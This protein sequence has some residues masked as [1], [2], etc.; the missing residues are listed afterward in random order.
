M[1]GHFLFNRMVKICYNKNT[2][3]LMKRIILIILSLVI[4]FLGYYMVIFEPN[5]I[6]IE[7]QI[8]AIENLPQSFE[9]VRIVHLTD[10]HS[11]WFGWREKK[12]LQILEELEPDFVFL[13]GDFVDPMTK[14]ITDRELNSVKVFWQELGEKYE[15][16][17]FAV[18]GNHDP[19]SLKNL[20]EKSG[21][22]VLDNENKKLKRDK[23]FIFLIGVDDP[24]TGRD[25]LSR[26]TK[27]IQENR[28]KILLAHAPDI[29]SEA[30]EKRIDL[31][32]VGDTH[33]S[34][35][36]IPILNPILKYLKPLTKYGRK[37]TSGLFRVKDTYLYVN[38]GIGTSLIPIRFNCPPEIALIELRAK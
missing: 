23:E 37:Y 24:R 35:V 1:I 13:T 5:N 12:I 6:K 2:K 15:N 27:G 10:L 29:I 32:L 18:L 16:R 19:Q 3:M 7:K 14:L 9:G 28:P 20:L 38:R 33:G 21:I 34:Q 30:V 26:A 11:L 8:L 31:V 36:N 4:L 22:N 25:D 17:I